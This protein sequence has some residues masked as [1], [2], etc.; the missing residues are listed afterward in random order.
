MAGGS[1]VHSIA[2]DK[3][4]GRW[5]VALLGLDAFWIGVVGWV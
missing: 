2:A 1:A 5:T 3:R 4:T